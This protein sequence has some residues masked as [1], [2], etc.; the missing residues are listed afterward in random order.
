MAVER[1]GLDERFGFFLALL[2]PFI[3]CLTQ[4][5]LWSFISPFVWFLFFPAVFFSARVGGRISAGIAAT[6]IS[7]GLVWFIFVPPQFSV[8]MKNPNNLF[9]V[10][11]FMVMGVLFSLTHDRLRKANRKTIEALESAR[12]AHEKINA[13]YRKTLELDKLKTQ[14]F[15]NVSHELR[16]PL[17]LIL[18]PLHKLLADAGVSAALRCNLEVMQ[19]NAQLLYH[20]VSDLLDISKIEAGRMDVRYSRLDLARLLRVTAS[21]FESVALDRGIRYTV[22][23]PETLPAQVDGE[24]FQRIL[25]NL[26]AN[27][28]KFVPDGGTIGVTLDRRNNRAVVEVM[29]NGPGV[30]AVMRTAIFE[31]FYQVEGDAAR[32][33][34]GTGLGLSIVS[35]F[36]DLQKGTI[37]CGE[38][39]GGG[40]L[41][42]LTLP[43]DAPPDAIIE[44]EFK[45]LDSMA[46]P[47]ISAASP[48]GQSPASSLPAAP[49]SLDNCPLI[50]VVE[51]NKDM[52]AYIVDILKPH[53]RV[54]SAFNGEE[55]LARAMQAKPDMI[56]T[57][58][59]MPKMS[60]DRMVAELRNCNDMADVRIVM[61]TAKA[62]DELRVR[63]LQQGVQ[64]YLNKPFSDDELLARVGGLL[65]DRRR[66]V[67][68]LRASEAKFR[69]LFENLLNSLAHCRLICRDGVPVNY[70]YIEVNPAFE[71]MTGLSRVQ[72][73]TVAEVIPGY[74]NE[75]HEL[76]DTF[77]QVA[78]TG[79]AVQLEHYFASSD[80][81][82]KLAVYS[83]TKDEIA[84]I[85][86]DITD[87]KKA[88]EEVL[89][90]NAVL[91]QRVAARTAELVAANQELDAFAYAVS[92]DLRAP[93]RAMSGFSQ[94]LLEDYGD[95]LASEA[96]LYLD[97]I[98]IGS[99]RMGE[100]I[101]GLL[102]LSRSTRSRLHRVEVDLSAMAE[103]LLRELAAEEP[104]R[105]VVWE[106]EPNLLAQ[107]DATM[108]E[109]V[110][111]N[112]LA[113]AWKY[114]S[115]R[116]EAT[117]KVFSRDEGVQQIFCIADNGAGFDENHAAKL[118]QPFQRLHRQ[119]EFPGIGIGLATAQRIIHRHGGTIAAEG[120]RDRGATF[121]FSLP[122][123]HKQGISS[124][125]K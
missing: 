8:G 12:A 9:S 106:I 33:H 120:Q 124:Y 47:G 54:L 81:W 92:H 42:T 116:D 36:V 60:G 110:M 49:S 104:G 1:E 14:F 25:I 70:E 102:T 19:R 46:A 107:G 67:D 3:A 96:R 113:N 115:R 20:H 52:N 82:Q 18:G 84:I 57:D 68:Q 109:V 22:S 43:L 122:Q 29:D 28:F 91:E 38:A 121:S 34:G 4:W 105:K 59:M 6:I 89:R 101:D 24:K 53:Y 26:L 27:S 93:L 44:E 100:L 95:G 88:E 56:I 76:L 63:L 74:C 90:L 103:N 45:H 35:E 123:Y 31:R 87:R 75:N 23:T 16:T 117:I 99:R 83:P 10:G 61:L 15:S 94:A 32:P 118:F 5:L 58:V 51:D 79:H 21:N 65:A 13:L 119:E 41:F 11:L 40:A 85:S 50:L 86:E 64:E 125:E 62:D 39:P 72:G 108:V 66:S 97:Q 111:R 73:R 48:T 69:F 17:T 37:V 98:I 2:L 7:S 71:Q 30:P 112:L 55:G 114:T 80:T 78:A 77:G